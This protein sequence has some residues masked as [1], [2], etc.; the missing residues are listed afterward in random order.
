MPFTKSKVLSLSHNLMEFQ[1][2]KDPT[3]PVEI[4]DDHFSDFFDGKLPCHWHE[5]IELDLMLK[6]SATYHVDGDEILMAEGDIVMISPGM[7]H[8]AEA[9]S[10]EDTFVIGLTFDPKLLA[11]AEDSLLY[12]NYFAPLIRN[13]KFLCTD[14]ADIRASIRKLYDSQKDGSLDEYL[15]FSYLVQLWNAILH[16]PE[17]SEQSRIDSS[18]RQQS[19]E[20]KSMLNFIQEH[21]AENIKIN[22]LCLA[23]NVSRSECFRLFEKY[24]LFSPKE[25]LNNYRLTRASEYL[26]DENN[27]V[28]TVASLC[29]FDSPSYFSLQF[30]K[31]F[32]QT[33]L[34]YRTSQ[35]FT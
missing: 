32:G 24:S 4:Y 30:K 23:A 27:S 35:I 5:S 31:H 7:M 9:L 2:Y 15:C 1:T 8:Q 33:P 21:F 26:L 18:G 14:N 34:N 11:G 19:Q 13:Y 22:D 12:R 16:G 6:G 10:P 20:M 25:Y 3:F 29:G 17:M 28:A